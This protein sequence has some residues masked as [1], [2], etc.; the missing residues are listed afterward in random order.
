VIK[1]DIIILGKLGWGKTL[2]E[3]YLIKNMRSCRK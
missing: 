2:I 3:K 1:M